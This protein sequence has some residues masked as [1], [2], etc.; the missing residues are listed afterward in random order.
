MTLAEA[1]KLFE[2]DP[3]VRVLIENGAGTDNPGLPGHTYELGFKQLPAEGGE[4]HQLLLRR[5]RQAL[6]RRS[7]PA[8]ASTRTRPIPRRAR[9]QTL[10]GNGEADSWAVL[11]PYDWQPLPAANAVGYVTRRAHRA[12]HDRRPGQRRPLAAQ[13][14]AADTDIQ[15]TLSEVRPDD[16]EFYVQSGWL[17]AS[18]RAIDKKNSSKL[19]PRPTHLEE[20]AEPLPGRPVQPAARRSSSP[21]AHVFRAGSRIRHHASRRPAATAR[22]GRSTRRRRAA[23]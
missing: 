7:R 14:S 22:A 12:R 23:S 19:D 4:A 11:P 21:S 20:D 8:P 5:G 18:H 17:R 15:V 1:K 3:P 16:K 13:S 9:M 10:P 2:A 6:R